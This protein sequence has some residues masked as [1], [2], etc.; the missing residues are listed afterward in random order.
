M[1]RILTS[2]LFALMLTTPVVAGGCSDSANIPGTE[3]PETPDNVEI[4]KVLERYRIAFIN[5]DAAAVLATA[6]KT[7]H[8]EAGSEDPGDDVEYA[9]LGPLLRRR[10]AQ[11]DSIRFTMDYVGIEVH[12]DRA[13]V[14]VWIDAAFRMKPLLDTEGA[15]RT[16]PRYSRKQDHS[17]FELLREG[18]TW[19]IVRGL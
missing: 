11:L 13:V 14:R 4:L 5:R 6:H 18:K 9:D 19:L 3:I 7:Y 2:S 12:G 1:R 10:L 16:A 17:E 15:P 8:D